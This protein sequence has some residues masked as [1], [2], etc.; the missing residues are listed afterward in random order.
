MNTLKK[1]FL[2]ILTLLF[3]ISIFKDLT[4]G[5]VIQP[6]NQVPLDPSEKQEEQS[7]E[8]NHPEVTSSSKK[9][10]NVYMET[11]RYQVIQQTTKPGDTVLSII[12]SLNQ[13]ISSVQMEQI[14]HDFEQLNPGVNP[15]QIEPNSSYFFPVYKSDFEN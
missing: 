7:N 5:T 13:N 11:D 10:Q 3:I 6:I 8:E 2:T 12:D 14:I 9:D 15:H 1:I 4:V